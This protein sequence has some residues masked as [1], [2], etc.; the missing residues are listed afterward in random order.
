MRTDVHQHLWTPGLVAALARRSTPPRVRRDGDGWRLELAGEPPFALPPH[1]EG[2]AARAAALD[3]LGV[4]R[5][6][7]A[8][9]CA[10][11]VETL[12]P[13]DADAVV[14]AWEAD[15]DA[16]PEGLTAWG[17][18]S[19]TAPEPEIVDRA[20]ARGR[21]GLALPTTAMATP[22][23]L[24]RIGGLL[25]RLEARDAPL[26]V[27]PGPARPGATLPALTDYVASL[28]AAWHV[29]AVAG[30]PAHPRLRV[31]FAALAG[32]A[33]MHAERLGARGHAALARA[34]LA[35]ARVF[36]DTSTYGPRAIEAMRAAVGDGA[37]VHGSDF[38]YARPT[39]APAGLERALLEDNPATLLGATA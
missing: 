33:P 15:A 25:E 29:W 18:A 30:R 3:G 36:Y 34:A 17:A 10:L 9:S 7:L 16:L 23:D 12:A 28:N 39:G 1:P 13:A 24:E 22:A 19:L 21:V 8:L 38:P 32:L 27:H 37:L 14:D 20:L 5:A 11:G 31:L 26:F 6:V 2:A 35:D 4:D